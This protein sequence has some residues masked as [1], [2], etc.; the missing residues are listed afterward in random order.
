MLGNLL[1]WGV[2]AWFVYRQV[3]RLDW[4][5]DAPLPGQ[6]VRKG[7]GHPLTDKQI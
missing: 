3:S 5:D 4:P 7:S 6:P 1:L 2:L